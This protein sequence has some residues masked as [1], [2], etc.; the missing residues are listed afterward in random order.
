MA[1]NSLH[2]YG[3]AKVKLSLCFTKHYAMKTY[4]GMEVQLHTL[5]D[6]GSIWRWVV[7]FT[8]RFYRKSSK[9]LLS[10]HNTIW[11]RNSEDLDLNL[12]CRESLRSR[13][14]C[15]VKRLINMASP[16]RIL[17]QFPLQLSLTKPEVRLFQFISPAVKVEKFVS[18]CIPG[19]PTT[20]FG[21]WHISPWMKVQACIT[22]NNGKLFSF[23]N[24][25]TT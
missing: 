23:L 11:S 22:Q 15:S 18:C 8:P 6:L 10:Y 14:K 12:H 21:S 4:W 25:V 24:W 9:T 1:D 7:S 5:F 16:S 19:R 2:I 17:K 20:H 3:K 13:I